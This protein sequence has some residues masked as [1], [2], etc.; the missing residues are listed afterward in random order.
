L[1]GFLSVALFGVAAQAGFIIDSFPAANQLGGNGIGIKGTA[2]SL[3][4]TD[5]GAGIFGGTRDA[6]LTLVTASSK[7]AGVNLKV[8]GGSSKLAYTSGNGANTAD[9]L[10]ELIYNGVSGIPTFPLDFT[11]DAGVTL[12]VLSHNNPGNTESTLFK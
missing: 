11:G 1:C 3:L 7:N 5:S 12:D 2:G 4:A 8:V 10:F 9:G 6:T